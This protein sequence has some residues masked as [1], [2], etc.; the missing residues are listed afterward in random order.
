MFQFLKNFLGFISFKSDIVRAVEAEATANRYRGWE[1]KKEELLQGIKAS[2]AAGN[3]TY[4]PN[5]FTA[6]RWLEDGSPIRAFL[7]AEGFKIKTE[8]HYG[9]HYIAWDRL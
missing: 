3:F 2:A 4:S 5:L 7:L 8:Y 6:A 1:A 9:S